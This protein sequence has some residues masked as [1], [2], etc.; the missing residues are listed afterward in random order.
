MVRNAY[1]LHIE[2]PR[3]RAYMQACYD[4]CKSFAN[5]NPIPV[6]GYNG[7]HYKDICNEYGID[8][9][10]YY[11]EMMKDDPKVITRAFSCS[12]GHFKIWQMIVESGEPGVVLE[13]DAI[14][15][16]DFTNLPVSDGEILWL[17]PRI[18]HEH[19]Y[20]YPVNSTPEI[21][22]VDRWEGT[23]AYAITPATAQY[24]LGKMKEH[25]LND[26]IDGQLGMRNIF[27]VGM[28]TVDPPPV[29]AVVGN[30]ESCIE[31]TGN[32]GFWNAMYTNRFLENFRRGAQLAPVREV[33]FKDRTFSK[34]LLPINQIIKPITGNK[35]DVLIVNS[36]EGYE[37]LKLGNELLKHNDSSMVVL[38]TS[39]DQQL[40]SYNLYFSWYYMKAPVAPVADTTPVLRAAVSDPDT[41][42]NVIYYRAQGS[43][44]KMLTDVIFCWNLLRNDSILIIDGADQEVVDNFMKVV[45]PASL[46][47]ASE[48]ITVLQK[49]ATVV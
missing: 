24:L 12:A 33:S 34:H 15:K 31:Q 30:R 21:V 8:T 27:D 25:G 32:P 23:H 20:N 35:N 17:G 2:D 18:E 37:A 47:Y 13:H 9:I 49:Y 42:Y 43:F 10:P 40:V 36:S 28:A 16:G 38:T 1:I 46:R 48:N 19:D 44:E 4:S 11:L 6:Q 5:I 3:S 26:S 22:R 29:V 7:V 45:S 41:R 39:K 14:V